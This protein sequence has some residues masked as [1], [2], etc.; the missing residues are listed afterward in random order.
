MKAHRIPRGMALGLLA[1]AASSLHAGEPATRLVRVSGSATHQ[2]A[3]LGLLPTAAQDYGTFTWMELSDAGVTRLREAGVVH[4]VRADAFTLRLG[5]QSFDPREAVPEAQPG[6]GAQRR[7]GPGFHL[8]QFVG[9]PRAAWV[10]DLERNGLRVVQ[11]I[12]PFSYIVWGEPAGTTKALADQN[13]RWT[14]EFIPAYR[15]QP[16]WRNLSAD[17]VRVKV[18]MYRGADPEATIAGIEALGGVFE[19]RG[20]INQTFESVGFTIPGNRLQA[21]ARV[22]G[23]YSAK[24]VSTDGGLRG[25]M[26]NQVCVNNVNG[27]NLA[28]PG[29]AA[30]LSGVGLDGS[31]II[32][33]NVDG[34][35]QHDHVD[36]V[37]RMLS[38]SG[39]TC[40]GSATDSHGTHTAGIMAADGSSGVTDGYGFLRG[41][42][43]APGANLVEQV[44][45]PY[46]T[47]TDGML[48][49]MTDSYNNG[50]L[51]SGNSWGPSGSALGY[52]D[53]TMQ[54]DVGVRDAVP[55]TPG[56][57]PLT[58]V[59]SIMNGYG[60]TSTQGTPDDAK[61]IFTIGSTKMQTSGGSQILQ[62]DDLSSNT[63]HGPARDGRTIPHM[64]APGCSVDSTVTGDSYT[65]MCGTSMASPHVAGA[66]A[67]FI[68]Y[69]RGLPDYVADPSAA[70]IKAAFLPVAIDLA[71][72]D[73]ANGGTLGH[74]FDSKQG[75]GRMDL[76]AVVDP[77][78]AVAYHDNPVVFDNTGEEWSMIVSADDPAKPLRVMLVWTD[79][80]GHGLGGS[81]P[82]WN[83]DLDLIVESGANSYRGNNFAAS[84]WSQTGGSADYR[85]N[86]E[87]VF[88]GPTAS[89]QYTLRVLASSI[90]SDAIPGVGDT[91]DQDFALV[92]Y[93][94]SVGPTP[95]LA[96][97]QLVS[98]PANAPATITL[99]GTDDGQP[100]PPAA[101][102][103]IVTSLPT[104]ELA[105]AADDHVILPGELPY[106]LVGDQV[107]YQPCGTYIGSD[108][109]EFKVNDGGTPPEG[110]DSNIATVSINITAGGAKR[111]YSYSLD[112]NP[113]WGT[114]GLWEH[115]IPL[116][117]GTHAGDPGEGYT[118]DNVYGYNLAGD[119]ADSSPVYYL[120]TAAIDCAEISDTE[121]RF[122]RW[123]GVEEH[124]FD[125]ASIDVSNNGSDW[126]PVWENPDDDVNES[127]WSYPSYD[128]SAT[129]DGQSTV[130][131]RW[132][133]GPTDGTVSYPG[134]NIDDVEIW[135]DSPTDA[136]DFTG[137]GLVTLEDHAAFVDCLTGPGNGVPPGCLCKDLDGDDDVDL[138]DFRDFQQGFGEA[139]KGGSRGLP[140]ATASTLSKR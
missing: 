129:A 136:R 69:Y 7:S 45:S 20:V 133:M 68:E 30:W 15:V 16:R 11:Y 113:G 34:G 4:E 93:N 54:V 112:D 23:V 116:E 58:Y 120:T 32:I 67:L 77:D 66:V 25:E 35:I 121:L 21:T 106:T 64:V 57:Q 128:I 131:V 111:I 102:T 3:D 115:G 123:L 49:L 124:Q 39:T 100:D 65:T 80:P 86:T 83:N 99:T 74:P 98:T 109:F 13:V 94:C 92:C 43:V 127:A 88:I 27:S 40:G 17:P 96:E 6:W 12:A 53:D 29:Y 103:Y 47:Y 114:Q 1:I 14:G 97:D 61:N 78:V 37:N 107:V 46:Y 42:G 44:Y 38:C 10:K 18:L 41:Q 91:T 28:F 22:P 140:N 52:D 139:S 119:Y 122:R 73:D 85:N 24:P 70:L 48:M 84:G 118:G 104:F 9:P 56:N 2:A 79:A 126:I 82:A 90:N 5:E 33:A 72:H 95:P 125:E 60:Q 135:G 50:A 117:G 89:G 138:D 105:D 75:W 81:S 130:Y 26:S 108:N 134:W 110:G 76:E 87:G 31:G 101:L 137:D 51:L 19:R 55:N 132:G 36:L 59:L 71:G 63:A 8:V 62:I